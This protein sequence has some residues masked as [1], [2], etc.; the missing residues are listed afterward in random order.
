MTISGGGGGQVSDVFFSPSAALRVTRQAMANTM[1]IGQWNPPL[2]HWW[3]P[4]HISQ[5][6]QAALQKSAYSILV[7]IERQPTD[8]FSYP[9]VDTAYLTL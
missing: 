5:A 2:S 6:F 9:Y 7:T 1:P 3:K 4:P 8:G